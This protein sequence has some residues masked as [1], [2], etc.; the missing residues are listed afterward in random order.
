[1]SER[2]LG[3]PTDFSDCELGI[4]KDPRQ[5]AAVAYLEAFGDPAEQTAWQKKPWDYPLSNAELKLS[6]DHWTAHWR[7]KRAKAPPT[8][9][10]LVNVQ[11]I[12]TIF[13]KFKSHLKGHYPVGKDTH[14]VYHGLA[15]WG[16]LAIQLRQ[17]V[18]HA[19][20]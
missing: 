20:A 19:K 9:D 14:E 15:N 7:K 10:R 18:P 8:R 11:E 6:V 13:C 3:F 2:V 5:G 16:D 17:G 1:M 12:E 4:Y